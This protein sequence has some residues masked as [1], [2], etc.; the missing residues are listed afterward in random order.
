MW[1][2]ER[3]SVLAGLALL[4]VTAACGFSPAYAPG[5]AGS[6]LRNQILANAPGDK[7]GYFFVERIEDRLGRN[8][9]APYQLN[10]TLAL[11]VDGLAITPDESTL[12]YHLNGT[13]DFQVIERS[14]GKEMTRGTVRNFVAFSAIGTTIATRASEDDAERRLMVMLADQ[15]VTRLM[16]TSKTWLP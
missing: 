16:A 9:S 4:G 7:L 11:S 2:S 6:V 5:G 13:M 1:Y 8:D 10:Y 15:I 14:S 3:R 12:R